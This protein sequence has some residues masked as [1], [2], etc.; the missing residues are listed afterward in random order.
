MA[1]LKLEQITKSFD[2]ELVLKILVNN[3]RE[4][5]IAANSS[6]RRQR[7]APSPP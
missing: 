5:N 6:E 4:P 7:F 2:N 1:N 3:I